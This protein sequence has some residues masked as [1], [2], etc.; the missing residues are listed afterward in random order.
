MLDLKLRYE[1]RG[2]RL[3]GTTIDFNNDSKTGALDMAAKDFLAIT[4][5]S[6]D[7]IK[8]IKA[9]A[10]GSNKAVVLV[11]NR[12]H[13]KS[14][15]MAVISAVAERADNHRRF[16]ARHLGDVSRRAEVGG[17]E[18]VLRGR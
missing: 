1:F 4:Y 15:L 6:I 2:A 16:L 12:G 11:G 9:V 17:V 14:H 13:G 18:R 7:L 10:P 8:S 5:P 3:R